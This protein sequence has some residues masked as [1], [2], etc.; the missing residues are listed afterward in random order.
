MAK[1]FKDWVDEFVEHGAN[2]KN[3]VKWPEEAGGGS[4]TKVVTELPQV[5]E[6]YIIYELQ[7]TSK[8]SYGWMFT[9]PFTGNSK[10]IQLVFDTYE[11]MTTTMNEIK[12]IEG[13]TYP[14]CFVAYI[15]NTNQMYMLNPVVTDQPHWE[16]KELPKQDDESGTDYAFKVEYTENRGPIV[17]T[18][19][20]T[21]YILKEFVGNERPVVDGGFEYSGVTLDDKEVYFGSS[22]LGGVLSNIAY[23]R[24]IML[25]TSFVGAPGAFTYDKLPDTVELETKCYNLLRLSGTIGF[26]ITPFVIYNTTDN[27]YYVLNPKTNKYQWYNNLEDRENCYFAQSGDYEGEPPHYTGELEWQYEG[28]FDEYLESDLKAIAFTEIPYNDIINHNPPFDSEGSSVCAFRPKNEE[29]IT[30]YWIYTKGEWVNVDEIGELNTIT[31]PVKSINHS[32]LIPLNKIHF[33]LGGKELG[34]VTVQSED[35]EHDDYGYLVVPLLDNA[36]ASYQLHIVFDNDVTIGSD[37]RFTNYPS[38]SVMEN[39]PYIQIISSTT[40]Y[41]FEIFVGGLLLNNSMTN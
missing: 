29:E 34:L 19:Q 18:C 7:E 20:Y 13:N 21:Y 10:G 22:K 24:F 4:G 2:P 11:Q 25:Q 16:F 15:R 23:P 26:D 3:V 12:V 28:S 5:G 33:S 31:I 32:A 38:F 37:C 35:P 14:D 30:S 17:V 27:A 6:E 8:A 41:D 36:N 9:L 39:N 40:E 1:E